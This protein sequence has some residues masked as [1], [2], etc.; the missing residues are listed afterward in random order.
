MATLFVVA[1]PIGNLSDIS[2]RAVDV[3]TNV[4]LIACEDTRH[5]RILLERYQIKTPVISYHQHSSLQK[6]DWLVDQLAAGKDVALISDAGTPGISDPGGI[7]VEKVQLHN[8]VAVEPILLISVPGP[9]AVSTALAVAGLPA[10]SYLFLGFLPKK[11]SRQTLLTTL[12]RL[13]KRLT[14][15]IVFFESAQRINKT[16]RDLALYSEKSP[17]N[18]GKIE[19]PQVFL[20]RELTKQFEENWRGSLTEAII[21]TDT[22]QKGEFTV[23]LYASK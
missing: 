20:G 18:S 23:V 13:D 2:P 7:F 16:L 12:T 19:S 8:R 11:K 4:D 3:L 6:I 14:S 17:G 21:K 22:P 1:T 15:T 5:S 9:S 10:D